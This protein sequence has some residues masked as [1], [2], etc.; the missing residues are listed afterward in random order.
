MRIVR[1][2][3]VL[4]IGKIAKT[5]SLAFHYELQISLDLS[6]RG[7]VKIREIQMSSFR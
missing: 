4:E 5:I 3:S 7:K 6:S 1:I 2:F